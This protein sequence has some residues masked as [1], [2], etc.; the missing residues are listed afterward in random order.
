MK[1]LLVFIK[2]IKDNSGQIIKTVVWLVIVCFAFASLYTCRKA[3]H[4]RVE[5]DKQSI[6]SVVVTHIQVRDTIVICCTPN[7]NQKTDTIGQRTR[8]VYAH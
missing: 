7:C 1:Y 4:V 3:F 5:A 2:W 6:D 8:K